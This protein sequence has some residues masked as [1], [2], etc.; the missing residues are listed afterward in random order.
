MNMYTN[1]GKILD[2]ILVL[3]IFVPS[4]CPTVCKLGGAIPLVPSVGTV[5]IKHT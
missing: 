1:S 3:H 2:Y 5:L 4:F